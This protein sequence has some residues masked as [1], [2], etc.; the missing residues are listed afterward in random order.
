MPLKAQTAK[1]DAAKKASEQATITPA[2]GRMPFQRRDR[3]P[4]IAGSV[5]AA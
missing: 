4:A 1:F 2:V 3:M 5:S